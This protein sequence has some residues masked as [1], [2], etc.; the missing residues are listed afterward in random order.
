MDRS[1]VVRGVVSRPDIRARGSK[2]GVVNTEPNELTLE[3]A[4]VLGATGFWRD[5][6]PRQIAE[7]QLYTSLL[8]MPFS[9]FHQAVEETLG[10]PV[11]IHEF[12]SIGTEV[13]KRELRGEKAAPSFDEIL[14]L[15]PTD[16]R[17][18]ILVTS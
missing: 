15:I 7:F 6:T 9:V 5:M 4:L 2:G 8:C 16:K 1:D 14:A 17:L 3:Q 13:L 11:F 18:T 10:R 12:G